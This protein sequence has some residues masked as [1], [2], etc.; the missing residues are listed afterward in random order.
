S[1]RRR[2]AS[3]SSPRTTTSSPPCRR[4]VQLSAVENRSRRSGRAFGLVDRRGWRRRRRHRCR[5]GV[6]R[7]VVGSHPASRWPAP[8]RPPSPSTSPRLYPF[9]ALLPIPHRPPQGGRV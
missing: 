6:R 5:G 9:P 2:L 8:L 7:G 1:A 4:E 3:V